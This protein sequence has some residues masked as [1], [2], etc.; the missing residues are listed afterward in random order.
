ME[1]V[2]LYVDR[3]GAPPGA[4]GYGGALPP[5]GAGPEH[6]P[7]HEGRSAAPAVPGL[8]RRP[9]DAE[10]ASAWDEAARALLEAG[11]APDVVIRPTTEPAPDLS[12]A[13]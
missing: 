12:P 11:G 7:E 1:Q 9:A 8:G 6:G 5:A 4:S 10:A 13:L 2:A 3:W